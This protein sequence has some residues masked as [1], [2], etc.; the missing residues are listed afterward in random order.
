MENPVQ[1]GFPLGSECH[2]VEL[3][4]KSKLIFEMKFS[5]IWYH[6]ANNLL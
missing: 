1:N 3:K 5:A 6:Y 4:A 2:V